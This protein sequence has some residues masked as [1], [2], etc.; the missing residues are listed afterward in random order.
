MLYLQRYTHTHTHTHTGRSLAKWVCAQLLSCAWLF[1][2]P[3]TVSHQ[4]LCP[5]NSPGKNTGMGCHFLL[6]GFLN[7]GVEPASPV[8]PALA[9]RFFTTEPL[10]LLKVPIIWLLSFLC[11]LTSSHLPVSLLHTGEVESV[12]PLHIL[13]F[14]F[15]KKESACGSR[16]EKDKTARMICCAVGAQLQYLKGPVSLFFTCNCDSVSSVVSEIRRCI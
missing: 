8:F 15:S 16:V 1:A 13:L 11:I 9:D 10:Q 4:A 3:W 6:Q 5:W 7:P 12:S 14:C 2:T